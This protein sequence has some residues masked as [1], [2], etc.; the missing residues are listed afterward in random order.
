M[1]SSWRAVGMAALFFSVAPVSIFAALAD[2]ADTCV[3]G[4]GDEKI[5]ACT[6][7]IESGKWKGRDLAWAYTNRGC[8]YNAKKDYAHA[9]A[10]ET[11]AIRLNPEGA[12]AYIC[13]GWAYDGK[14][15]Y[16][17]AIAG[18]TE[19][20]RL[21]P[22]DAN[23]YI[24]RGWAYDDTDQFDRAIA[25]ETKAIQLRPGDRAVFNNRGSAH[26]D[27]LEFDAAIADFTEAIRIDA[28]YGAAYRNRARAYLYTGKLAESLADINQASAFDPK[29]A[30]GALWLDIISRRNNVASRLSQ[31]SAQLDMTVWPAPVV[32]MFLGQMTPAAVLAVADNPDPRVK[33]DQVCEANFYSGE[34]ALR[35]GAKDEAARLFKTAARDCPHGLDEYVAAK[36]EARALGAA[37]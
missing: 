25:D 10:D 5:A 2:D 7:A 29:N 9:I 3:K 34:I 28:K 22:E 18:E 30:H 13:R 1:D 11:E 32:R 21:N 4:S 17:H 14:E 31:I 12:N 37:P 27:K 24:Y 35:I 36:A 16:A 33:K 26:F 6:A 19:A 8:A 23:A 20:I 15:D